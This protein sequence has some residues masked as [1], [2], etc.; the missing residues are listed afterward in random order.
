MQ[1]IKIRL[2]TGEERDCSYPSEE[3][4]FAETEANG[5]KVVEY[6]TCA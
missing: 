1:V 4:M 3:I 2:D 5:E 6:W